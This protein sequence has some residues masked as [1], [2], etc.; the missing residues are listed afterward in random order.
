MSTHLI[1]ENPR[2]SSFIITAL[3]A[4]I[5]LTIP[6]SVCRSNEIENEYAFAS[7]LIAS[8]D[9]DLA[10]LSL[11]RYVLF[12][13]NKPRVVK[14]RFICGS[15]YDMTDR[16]DRAASVFLEL[17]R[18]ESLPADYREHAAFL[19]IQSLFLNK[20][21]AG[22]HVQL[23]NLESL[24]STQ[25]ALPRPAMDTGIADPFPPDASATALPSSFAPGAL[26]ET[27]KGHRR[28]LKGFLGV[29]AGSREL[30]DMLPVETA[31]SELYQHS[32]DLKNQFQF[33]ETHPQKNPV[34]SGLLSTFI[35]G[36]G[37]FYNGRY[38]DGGVA[39]GIVAGG[40]YWTYDLFDRGDDSWGWTV[41][42]IT[43]LLYFGQIRNAVIDSV[44]INERSELEFKQNLIDDFFLRFTLSVKEDDLRFGVSF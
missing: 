35:P 20:D 41:G 22:Y 33:W 19:A 42:V 10:L 26:S 29:F 5:S 9:Y 21:L 30:A 34:T 4:L 1:L 2:I 15:L 14:A 17:A 13:T 11:R 6:S 28:Y 16:H 8:K 25:T 43:G 40:A 31:D 37:Q 38:W 36:A 44:K 7:T 3:I 23:D 12:G 27:A 24:V 39:L 32:R 18:D